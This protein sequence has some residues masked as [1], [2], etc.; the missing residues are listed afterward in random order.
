MPLRRTPGRVQVVFQEGSGSR[1]PP[2][3]R[4]SAVIACKAASGRRVVCLDRIEL[5]P[6][7][8]GQVR[9][10]Q[11]LLPIVIAPTSQSSPRSSACS[12]Q[13]SNL[14]LEVAAHTP[15]SENP[16]VV[17]PDFSL[18][19]AEVEV[20]SS[21]IRQP[22]SF[23]G[24]AS[25][26]GRRWRSRVPSIGVES[27]WPARRSTSSA[28]TPTHAESKPLDLRTAEARNVWW[29]RAEQGSIERRARSTSSCHCRWRF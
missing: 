19:F 1:A 7:L 22:G 17:E 9:L 16:I 14:D 18:V 24:A 8:E 20:P 15:L 4:C 27:R 13:P 6:A 25:E 3:D 28:K 21:S 2:P 12:D 10:L 26:E 11:R 29:R 5:K 23:R